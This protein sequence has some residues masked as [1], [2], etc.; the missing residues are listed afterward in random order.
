MR[1]MYE[2]KTV[3]LLQRD[4]NELIKKINARQDGKMLKKIKTLNGVLEERE[5]DYRI[6]EFSTTRYHT[7]ESGVKKK[8]I[9]KNAWKI[10][11]I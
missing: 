6:E 8:K 5:L 10:N 2:E 4:R 9:F 11:K 1:K 3:L 7:D